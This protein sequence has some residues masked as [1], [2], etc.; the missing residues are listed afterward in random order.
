[1]IFPL[2]Q[3]QPL[4]SSCWLMIIY[5]IT[6]TLLLPIVVVKG[7]TIRTT[8]M[9]T[10]I[11]TGSFNNKE[12][13]LRRIRTMTKISNDDKT[14]SS[15]A[16]RSTGEEEDVV[17]V[18]P[19]VAAQVWSCGHSSRIDLLEAIQEATEMALEGLPSDTTTTTTTNMKIVDLATVS[20]SSLYDA[21][22]SLVVPTVLSSA[23]GKQTEI[24]ELIGGTVSG[25]VSSVRNEGYG[26]I[27]TSSSSTL[28]DEND[29]DA[30]SSFSSACTGMESEGVPGVSIVLAILPDVELKTFHVFN[31]DVPDDVGRVPESVWK[32]AVGLTNFPSSNED[33][34]NANANDPVFLLTSSPSFQNQ[35]DD[36]LLGLSM[37]Y[38]PSASVVGGIASTVSSLTRAR[39]F[40]YSN[41][42]ET[43]AT[44]TL[45]EG[46]VGVAMVGD[47][48]CETRVAQGTKPV[49]GIYRVVSGQDATIR[50]IVLDETA[51]QEATNNDDDDEDEE[52]D[53]EDEDDLTKKTKAAKMAALYAKAT[54]PKP[55]LAEANFVMR[56]LSDDDQASMKKAILIGLE[57]SSSSLTPNELLRLARGEEYRW[58][59]YQVAS[60]GMKEGSVTLPPKEVT[61]IRPNTRVRFFVRDAKFG[62]KE[63]QALWTGYKKCRLE[64]TLLR[65]GDANEDKQQQQQQQ[66]EP[67]MAF[68]W[69]SLDR[70]DSFF[71]KPSYESRTLTE[72]LPNLPAVGGFFAKGV[73][74]KIDSKKEDKTVVHGSGTTYAL[75]SSKTKRPIYYPTTAT[76][77]EVNDNNNDD[78]ATNTNEGASAASA[79]S[80]ASP[81]AENGELILK[82][83]EVHSG[84]ALKVSTVEWSVAEKTEVPNVG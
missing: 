55:V 73:V 5:L 6:T 61:D 11:S 63:V 17:T 71:G 57:R 40:R 33:A 4:L 2:K 30:S 26:S 75:L 16:L 18:S 1:M 29:D 41:T 76:A 84:R 39:L 56:T 23:M 24:R 35:F 36:F 37:H 21:S 58:R 27:T 66:N 46:C 68:M 59:V 13:T 82:R 3:R 10:T 65:T 70:G 81:R 69:S 15:S 45:S 47:I 72:F 60:A 50:A 12:Q 83:R 62:R 74:G 80:A 22:P 53:D 38:G 44:T 25:Y 14:F 52:E 9:K 43:S 78:V 28:D 20:I 64:Q 51:T 32:Q 19:P 34:K 54:M 31:D 8:P 48:T 7:F 79:A 49:G 67:C 77:S 42:E